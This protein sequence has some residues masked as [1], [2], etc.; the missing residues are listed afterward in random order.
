[1]CSGKVTSSCSTSDT[2]RVNLVTNPG[3]SRECSQRTICTCLLR[4]AYSR[5]GGGITSAA[6]YGVP[7]KISK[8]H[9]SWRSEKY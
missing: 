4:D 2:R 9:G 6:I 5:R 8:I 7:G 1:M 3:I